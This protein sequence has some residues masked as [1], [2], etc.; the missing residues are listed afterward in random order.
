M[1]NIN[2]EVRGATALYAAMIVAAVALLLGS[3]W[4]PA[5]TSFQ[6][7]TQV[8]ASQMVVTEAAPGHVS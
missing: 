3:I 8:P 6:A 5:T 7:Q 4:S 1:T 2:G